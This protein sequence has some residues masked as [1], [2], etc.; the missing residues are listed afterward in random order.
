MHLP[1]AGAL[2]RSLPVSALCC[3]LAAGL[4]SCDGAEHREISA[5]ASDANEL[6]E[7]TVVAST[8]GVLDVLMIAR[9]ATVA[10]LAPLSPTALVYEI[11]RRPADP[12][13]LCPAEGNSGPIRIVL[14]SAER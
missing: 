1:S 12:S 9:P 6:R 8:Q 11:C 10:Q 3:L 7:P 4:I 13:A 2:G 5:T 14:T